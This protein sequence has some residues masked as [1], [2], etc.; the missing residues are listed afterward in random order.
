MTRLGTREGR[1]SRGPSA[2]IAHLTLRLRGT[3]LGPKPDGAAHGGGNVATARAT[4][5]RGIGDAGGANRR[6]RSVVSLA[7]R[8]EVLGPRE[9]FAK[10]LVGHLERVLPGAVGV[11]S[12]HVAESDGE[13]RFAEGLAE[14]GL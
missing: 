1:A 13:L 10:A 14:H 5:W 3:R 4:R 2:L 8:R 6:E 11:P 7:L 12:H 9:A